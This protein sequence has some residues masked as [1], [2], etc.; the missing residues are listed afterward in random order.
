MKGI[1]GILSTICILEFICI[2]WLFKK[3]NL[4]NKSD[5]QGKINFFRDLWGKF[6]FY[7]IATSIIELFFGSLFFEKVIGLNEINSWVSIVLGLVAL[8][9][10]I[11]SLF[12]SF[13]NVDQSISS[14]EKSINIMND[15][16]DDI[17]QEITN[18]KETMKV[19]FNKL[20]DDI[21]FH[22]IDTGKKE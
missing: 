8:I 21:R 9:I 16:K 22:Y 20:H 10:G 3:V 2:C 11:I 18:M 1:I 17:K 12:L 14:Q 15:V 19:G 4:N 6:V 7:V 5:L 13:Y